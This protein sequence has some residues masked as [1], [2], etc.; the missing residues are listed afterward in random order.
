MSNNIKSI[1]IGIAG[2]S[3]I[4]TAIRDVLT[5]LNGV[6]L[7]IGIILLALGSTIADRDREKKREHEY[8]EFMRELYGTIKDDEKPAEN[9]PA[10]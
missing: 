7:V 9:E 4:L 3:M 5:T 1:I 2:I 6:F 8:Q 10:P